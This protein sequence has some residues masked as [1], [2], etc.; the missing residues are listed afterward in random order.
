MPDLRL[1][2]PK[3]VP[4]V[5]IAVAIL[6]VTFSWVPLTLIAKHT[7]VKH[8]KP[9]IH[10]FQDMDNQPKLKAQA[11]SP[12]FADGRAMRQPVAGTVARGHL[13]DQDDLHLGYT[14][15]TVEGQAVPD[16]LTG[17]P[18]GVEVD[19]FY[20]ARGKE[21]FET[22]CYTCH[23]VS[24]YGNGP[25]NQRAVAL[26]IGDG[27]LSY[28]TAWAPSADLHAL[29][30]GR[31]KYGADVY[32]NGQLYNV[33]THGKATMAGYG[34]AIPV[35]DRWAIVAYVRALQLSQNAEAAKVAMDNAALE[36]KNPQTAE[37]T[38]ASPE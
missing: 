10:L 25:T 36:N 16:F 8:D 34:H 20:L 7:Q 18:E 26:Q 11:A 37:L 14:V 3:S 35:E 21:K 13:N 17:F 29:E 12:I 23:G 6:G 1:F 27:T 28:G 24:G 30:N 22:F 9:R 31:L 15:K 38:G 33:I 19:S 32:P 2:L 4:M 5:L